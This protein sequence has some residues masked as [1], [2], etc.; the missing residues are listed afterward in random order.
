MQ[1][2]VLLG[3]EKNPRHGVW[4]A[5]YGHGLLGGPAPSANFRVLSTSLMHL[6]CAGLAGPTLPRGPNTMLL[7]PRFAGTIRAGN[8]VA[9]GLF[10]TA[11]AHKKAALD[12]GDLTGGR[13]GAF[14]DALVFSK[15]RARLGGARPSSHAYRPSCEAGWQPSRFAVSA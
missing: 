10:N 7:Q 11:Y 5:L 1:D 4:H 6:A 13:F 3:W 12:A 2:M 9:R 8:P 15:I 14:W